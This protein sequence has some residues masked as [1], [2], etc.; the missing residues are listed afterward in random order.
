LL[1]NILLFI[2]PIIKGFSAKLVYNRFW[3]RVN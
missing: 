3:M 2:K 1:E